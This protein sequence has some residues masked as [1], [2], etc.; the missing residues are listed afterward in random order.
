MVFRID[1]I[2]GTS[3]Y[4]TLKAPNAQWRLRV[5]L[6]STIHGCLGL[7]VALC[8]CCVPAAKSMDEFGNKLPKQSPSTFSKFRGDEVSNRAQV[9]REETRAR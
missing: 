9:H 2:S 3:P 6:V 5:L 7:Q 8:M 1:E 4:C